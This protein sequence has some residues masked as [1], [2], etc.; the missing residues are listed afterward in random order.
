[1]SDQRA[2]IL[3][4]LKLISFYTYLLFTKMFIRKINFV[5]IN[6]NQLINYDNIIN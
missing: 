4:T 3:L 2:A 1:M 5:T 6:Y